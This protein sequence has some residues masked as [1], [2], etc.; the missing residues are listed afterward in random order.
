MPVQC[1]THLSIKKCQKSV[2]KFWER[3]FRETNFS[4]YRLW[5]ICCRN[6]LGESNATISLNFDSKFTNSI[7]T[8]DL[9][10]FYKKKLQLMCVWRNMICKKEKYDLQKEQERR[11]TGRSKRS[12]PGAKFILSHSFKI[13][14]KQKK[15]SWWKQVA[16]HC[17]NSLLARLKLQ[18]SAL[19]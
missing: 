2:W 15:T 17:E 1:S 14:R 11:Q 8:N 7:K 6:D 18:I 4:N 13:Q 5:S 9:E 12:K 10:I 16:L 19:Q 3:F